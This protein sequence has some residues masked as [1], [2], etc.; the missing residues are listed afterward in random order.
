[1]SGPPVDCSRSRATLSF[2]PQ[3]E[4]SMSPKNVR[5]IKAIHELASAEEIAT[6]LAWY[7]VAQCVAITLA[8]QYS[9][10]ANQAIGVIAALSPRNKW[11][12]NLLDAE[13]LIAAY[14]AGGSEQALLT[15]VCTFGANKVKAIKILESG[16][17]TL[18]TALEILS[19]PKLREFASCIAG[20]PDCCIDG[21][22][23]CIWQ[24]SRVTLADVP[25]IGVKLR[26]EI[27][28]DYAQAAADLGLQAYELQ[29]ITWCAWRRIHGVT[30]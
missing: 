16:L 12:R 4:Q 24:G 29:A 22:A 19:G 3:T 5:N 10:P 1:V 9:I 26:R 21:H 20:L 15:K 23:W 7:G 18:P 6:G 17:E 25:A 8:D 28:A 11:S 14:K 27:K 30:K 2:I 13:Q